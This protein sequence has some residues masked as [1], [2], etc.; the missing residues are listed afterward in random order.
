MLQWKFILTDTGRIIKKM[1]KKKQ[2]KQRR[3]LKRIYKKE[4][5]GIYK[6][7]T[8]RE[9]LT[10]WLANANRGDTYYQQQKMINFFNDM[11]ENNAKH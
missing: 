10:S 5:A 8:T 9:S 2:G 7:G 6:K 1:D 3:K 11:E 4:Q